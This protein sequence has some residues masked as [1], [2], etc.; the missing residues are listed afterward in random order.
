M[1]PTA[2]PVKAGSPSASALTHSAPVRVLP[3]PRPPITAQVVHGLSVRQGGSWSG[4]AQW[5]QSRERARIREGGRL[6][7]KAGIRPLACECRIAARDLRA[8][9][10]QVE[11]GEPGGAFRFAGIR[12]IA[13]FLH[14]F[15][16]IEV[17]EEALEPAEIA[18]NLARIEGRLALQ[19]RI[20]P[21]D[22]SGD[23]AAQ[24]R[25]QVV[26]RAGTV[27][28]V[29]GGRGRLP[30]PQPLKKADAPY[31]PTPSAAARSESSTSGLRY[32]LS[33]AVR[34]DADHRAGS[35]RRRGLCAGGRQPQRKFQF[36]TVP[37][38]RPVSCAIAASVLSVVRTSFSTC[39]RKAIG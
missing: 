24:G 36:P 18:Q 7:R 35:F 26:A 38:R 34:R 21:L 19:G 5:S 11:G 37:G 2:E 16:R 3:E 27:P 22:L 10:G 13:E 6:A 25:P 33:T 28:A 23:M 12:P 17:V 20:E 8:Q 39:R 29:R 14:P 31:R 1:R 9:G 4:R 30:N 32:S 15:V